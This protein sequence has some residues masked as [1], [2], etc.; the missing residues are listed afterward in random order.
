MKNWKQAKD[1]Y[2]QDHLSKDL[3]QPQRRISALRAIESRFQANHPDIIN[4]K[5][6][7]KNINKESL[8]SL[9][10]KLKGKELNG[11]E[12]SVFNGLYKFSE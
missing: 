11:A 10:K 9:Y 6:V 4:D 3:V 1:A 8:I 5:N 2:V 12:K 7:F